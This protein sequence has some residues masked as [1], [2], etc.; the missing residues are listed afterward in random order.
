MLHFL[1]F[2]ETLL[3]GSIEKIALK[4]F[5]TPKYVCWYTT[6]DRRD[7]INLTNY[8]Y[9]I[10]SISSINYERHFNATVFF[11]YPCI[12][13]RHIK[14]TFLYLF[15][16]KRLKLNYKIKH[17]LVDNA[18]NRLIINVNIVNK[19]W[20]WFYFIHADAERYRTCNIFAK[21]S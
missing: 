1:C 16:A 12:S 17:F 4:I 10:L 21:V 9:K 18:V 11:I 20:Q 5:G 7:L 6:L 19:L 8:D 13:C 15:G 14:K 3:L 2:L